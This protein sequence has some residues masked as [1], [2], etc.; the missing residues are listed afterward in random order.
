MKLKISAYVIKYDSLLNKLKKR[1]DSLL[2]KLKKRKALWA[3]NLLVEY[4][5][6][7]YIIF[8]LNKN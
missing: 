5:S 8:S 6:A 3:F 4:C 7:S 1:N 2:I